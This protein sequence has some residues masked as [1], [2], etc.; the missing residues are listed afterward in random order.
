MEPGDGPPRS[1]LLGGNYP[2]TQKRQQSYEGGEQEEEQE[3]E[4]E[5]EQTELHEASWPKVTSP[6]TN[7]FWPSTFQSP[8]HVTEEED[9]ASTEEED[10]GEDK[11]EH[12]E[13]ELM[14]E[15]RLQTTT[16]GAIINPHLFS[17]HDEYPVAGSYMSELLVQHRFLPRSADTGRSHQ[18]MVLS[19]AGGRARLGFEGTGQML[20][21]RFLLGLVMGY[22]RFS[23]KGATGV[24]LSPTANHAQISPTEG[25]SGELGDLLPEWPALVRLLAKADGVPSIEDINELMET[26]NP[27]YDSSEDALREALVDFSADLDGLLAM[28]QEAIFVKGGGSGG[29]CVC[30]TLSSQLASSV[31]EGSGL[32]MEFLETMGK[33]LPA[34]QGALEEVGGGAEHGSGDQGRRHFGWGKRQEEDEDDGPEAYG[35]AA[36]RWLKEAWVLPDKPDEQPQDVPHFRRPSFKHGEFMNS[37]KHGESPPVDSKALGIETRTVTFDSERNS[38]LH[39]VPEGAKDTRASDNRASDNRYTPGASLFA[40]VSDERPEWL[41]DKAAKQAKQAQKGSFMTFI[42]EQE[43][44]LVHTQKGSGKVNKQKGSGKVNK[45]KGSGSSSGRRRGNRGS[46]SS[47]SS[48]SSGS[49]SEEGELEGADGNSAPILNDEQRAALEEERCRARIREIRRVQ[50]TLHAEVD[51]MEREEE[52]E[53]ERMGS[54]RWGGSQCVDDGPTSAS[55]A[56]SAFSRRSVG[57]AHAHG[58]WSP[59]SE[60]SVGSPDSDAMSPTMGTMGVFTH[61]HEHSRSMGRLVGAED[62]EDEHEQDELKRRPQHDLH[63]LA[64]SWHGLIVRDT[65]FKHSKA[66]RMYV[67]AGWHCGRLCHR[68]LHEEQEQ[69]TSEVVILAPA[70]TPKVHDRIEEEEEEEEKEE[71]KR[72]EEEHSEE[73]QRKGTQQDVSTDV[74]TDVNGAEGGGAGDSA[75]EMQADNGAHSKEQ[76][77]ASPGQEN[78]PPEEDA[79]EGAKRGKK[80]GKKKRKKGKRSQAFKAAFGCFGKIHKPERKPRGGAGDAVADQ[81]AAPPVAADAAEEALTKAA[82][83]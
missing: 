29:S 31:N 68:L 60:R 35:A 69:P 54:S 46:R 33:D 43:Q 72:R 56:S 34:I 32:G 51:A 1:T 57:A 71:E 4:Q 11:E 78:R 73:G 17:W 41:K 64:E 59:V 37:F 55:S 39:L 12:D 23:P 83:Q 14:E 27:I 65:F 58:L 36:D 50:L 81:A 26:V 40:E 9:E 53:E 49:G 79:T 75:G 62:A 15:V 8:K 80:G 21:A 28:V 7:S 6:S 24:C 18:Q 66:S 10:G 25:L 44:A 38:H 42:Q 61:E 16:L 45:Q 63:L 5:E 52:E 3:G 13:A 77:Q 48:R 76:D 67:A 82:Q 30:P 47:R 70:P 22:S 20:V 74:L 19:P 2:E